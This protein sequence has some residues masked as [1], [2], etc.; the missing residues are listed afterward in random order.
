[1][2]RLVPWRD[3]AVARRLLRAPAGAALLLLT[4]CTPGPSD[5]STPDATMAP[6]VETGPMPPE[7]PTVEAQGVA[8]EP[9]VA[10]WI[11]DD[12]VVR[13]GAQTDEDASAIELTTVPPTEPFT[14]TIGHPTV[15]PTLYVRLFDEL[16]AQNHPVGSGRQVDCTLDGSECRLTRS[17][18]EL[19]VTVDLAPETRAVV[20]QAAYTV[21][22]EVQE[23]VDGAPA[24]LTA[25]WGAIVTR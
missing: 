1:M 19:A 5:I 20:L 10:L 18:D 9:L 17:E 25:S 13:M 15:P 23:S 24:L 12:E 3:P 8:L 6:L 4:A 22:P 16:D 2:D 21:W 11:V 7:P 14:M